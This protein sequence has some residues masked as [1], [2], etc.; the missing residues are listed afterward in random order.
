MKKDNTTVT[1]LFVGMDTHKDSIATAEIAV[2][3]TVTAI[4]GRL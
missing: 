3:H 1:D 2:K 4:C